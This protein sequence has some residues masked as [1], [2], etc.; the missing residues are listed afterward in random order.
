MSPAHACCSL[1]ARR[2]LHARLID[3]ANPGS[4]D[5]RLFATLLAAR[6]GEDAPTTLDPSLGLSPARL[7]ALLARHFPRLRPGV[8]ETSP[9][10]AIPTPHAAFVA[11][12]RSLLMRE[13]GAA[14]HRG[15]AACLAAI[16]AHACLRP[17]H[18]WRDLGLDGR[19]DVSALLE[20]YFPALAA[21]NTAALR[22]KKFLAREV[23][24]D[25][26]APPA[27]APGCFGCE[28]HARCF[29]PGV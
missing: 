24:L 12:L 22:W 6:A 27:P 20:R 13:A 19:D 15:D 26:G 7:R 11:T 14:A 25:Q 28:D 18:L 9:P 4:T 29:P 5:A 10:T 8:V 3:A 2:A 16:I 1:A 17:D 21:R 23:A